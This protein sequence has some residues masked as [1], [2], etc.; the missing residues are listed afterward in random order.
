[1]Q[2]PME[3]WKRLVDEAGLAN[4]TRLIM[5]EHPGRGD[6]VKELDDLWEDLSV[7]QI[8][9]AILRDRS[10]RPTT[11]KAIEFWGQVRAGANATI[12]LPAPIVASPAV[13]CNS[14]LDL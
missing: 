3:P 7:F 12:P 8:Y 10:P 4:A 11:S 9:E 2:R 13:S 14:W 6:S 5:A 1:M